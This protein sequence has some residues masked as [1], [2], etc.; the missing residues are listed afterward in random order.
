MIDSI[1]IAD[2]GFPW[3]GWFWTGGGIVALLLVVL[4]LWLV[5]YSASVRETTEKIRNAAEIL[6]VIAI[7]AIPVGAAINGIVSTTLRTNEIHAQKI[8]AM[9]ELGYINPSFDSQVFTAVKDDKY[10]LGTITQDPALT[11]RIVM[12]DNGTDSE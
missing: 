11:W 2:P 10:V 4:I 9:E 7:I 1:T 5:S 3:Y 8:Q 6:L 12:I